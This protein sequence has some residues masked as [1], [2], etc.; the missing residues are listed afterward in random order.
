[1]TNG[2]YEAFDDPYSYKGTNV[3][4]NHLRTRDPDILEAF[5]LEMTTLRASTPCFRTFIPGRDAIEPC[6]LPRAATGSASPSTY[7]NR[8]TG[9]SLN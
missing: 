7:R 9:C 1:M 4:K 3:L 8:W 6:A 2:G 5:E